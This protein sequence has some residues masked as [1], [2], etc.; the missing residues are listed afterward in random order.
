MSE[1][2]PAPGTTPDNPL[3]VATP[4]EITKHTMD[5]GVIEKLRDA[6]IE[7]VQ[8]A[9]ERITDI[10]EK[11]PELLEDSVIKGKLDTI[12]TRL[13]ELGFDP[14]EEEIETQH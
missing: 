1:Q 13:E 10:L 5:I 11:H 8:R 4:E 6:D 2:F 9:F 3:R 12:I 7:T 14:L